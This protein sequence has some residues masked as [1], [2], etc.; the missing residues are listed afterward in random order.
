[1]MMKRKPRSGDPEGSAMSVRLAGRYA[2]ARREGS[3]WVVATQNGNEQ[4]RL[5]KDGWSDH[6]VVAEEAPAPVKP[7]FAVLNSTVAALERELD[8]GT[9]DDWLPQLH[10]AEIAHKNRSTALDAIEDRMEDQ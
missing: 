1:M 6:V 9:F 5:R 2:I 4:K 10:A 7:S 3:V 8:A